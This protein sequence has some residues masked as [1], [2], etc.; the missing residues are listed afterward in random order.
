M[1]H[2]VLLH[3]DKRYVFSHTKNLEFYCGREIEDSY[4]DCKKC[5]YCSPIEKFYCVIMDILNINIMYCDTE[6]KKQKRI[7][8]FF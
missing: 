4:P 5:G 7:T 2:G 3:F 8:D 6:R 1:G